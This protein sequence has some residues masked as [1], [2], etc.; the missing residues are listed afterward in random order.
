M[1]GSEVHLARFL[2]VVAAEGISLDREQVA[3]EEK[4]RL[5]YLFA[6]L[7]HQLT[8]NEVRLLLL[9]LGQIEVVLRYSCCPSSGQAL[10]GYHLLA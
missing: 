2:S 10:T 8:V 1:A 4:R 3:D 7:Q 9:C 6:S 5:V